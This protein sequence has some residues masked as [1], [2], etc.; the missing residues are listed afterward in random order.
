MDDDIE[1]KEKNKNA[2]KLEKKSSS[3]KHANKEA[4]H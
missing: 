1:E 3:K 4:S 2:E